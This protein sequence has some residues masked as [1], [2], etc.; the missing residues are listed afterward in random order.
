M[1]C[2]NIPVMAGVLV[3]ALVGGGLEEVGILVEVV[4]LLEVV[5]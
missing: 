3:A 1:A 4:V 2:V 5:L